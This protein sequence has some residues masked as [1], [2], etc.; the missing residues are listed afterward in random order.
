MPPPFGIFRVDTSA[1]ICPSCPVCGDNASVPEMEEGF[2]YRS[3]LCSY[4]FLRSVSSTAIV[5]DTAE[6]H[7]A[8]MSF[9]PV[10]FTDVCSLLYCDT[11]FQDW[12]IYQC[13][14][15]DASAKR[16]HHSSGG[17]APF[18]PDYPGRMADGESGAPIKRDGADMEKCFSSSAADDGIYAGSLFAAVLGYR[19]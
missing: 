7:H 4:V 15:S 13:I 3:Y 1:G 10:Y 6:Y 17:D 14:Y 8:G 11:D 16:G 12:G 19:G 5:R 2:L 9:L 18:C